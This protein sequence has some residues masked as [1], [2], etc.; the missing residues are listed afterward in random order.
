MDNTPVRIDYATLADLNPV[1]RFAAAGRVQDQ[2]RTSQARYRSMIVMELWEAVRDPVPAPVV[3]KTLGISVQRVHQLL[4]TGQEW[5]WS[6][7]VNPA[8]GVLFDP[9]HKAELADVL[10]GEGDTW[11]PLARRVRRTRGQYVALTL[12]ELTAILPIVEAIPEVYAER[13][14]L[15]PTIRDAWYDA[16]HEQH[17]RF[18]ADLLAMANL[19]PFPESWADLY[20]RRR[21]CTVLERSLA[22]APGRLWS[23]CLDE[24]AEDVSKGRLRDLVQRAGRADLLSSVDM[25]M[26]E[27]REW[28]A[29]V[30]TWRWGLANA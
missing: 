29:R 16:A 24:G 11:A 14:R 8:V 22:H 15:V 3:A 13:D 5:L 25:S 21:A 1:D 28:Q 17:T 9:S 26:D 10:D 12:R 2:A 7:V 30:G 18:N 6:T 27:R 20:G 4:T 19:S 23:P